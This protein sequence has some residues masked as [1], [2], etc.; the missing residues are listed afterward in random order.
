[1]NHV[2]PRH[3]VVAVALCAAPI[4]AGCS[5]GD[6]SGQETSTTPTTTTVSVQDVC[7]DVADQA[8]VLVEAV[9]GLATGDATTEQ[10]AAAADELSGAF[11]DA[12][13][14]L[15]PDARAD[16]DLAGQALA[17]M[18]D[19][20]TA[21]PVDTAGLRAATTDLVAALGDAAA[22]CSPGSST[23]PPGTVTTA[24]TS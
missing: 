13:A 1:M 2:T 14:A 9:G 11:D 20:V 19:A 8:R 4:L 24:P 21:Q 3:L 5:T 18:R 6:Q 23:E 17:R 15:G 7:L 16:L 10:V 22:V 12:V